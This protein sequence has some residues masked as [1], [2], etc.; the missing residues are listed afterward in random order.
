MFD[1]SD[2]TTRIS[3]HVYSNFKER[4]TKKPSATFR[5][6]WLRRLW[7]FPPRCSVVCAASVKGYLGKLGIRRKRFFVFFRKKFKKLCH[8]P[9]QTPFVVF[10]LSLKLQI[11]LKSGCF[12]LI[13]DLEDRDGDSFLA[14]NPRKSESILH[15]SWKTP[16]N[17]L[18]IQ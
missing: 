16:Q 11:S 5:S 8:Y 4:E 10:H 13:C 12:R 15:D 6:V 2:Q 9:F 17:L 14:Q 7:M 18:I 1:R 3:L